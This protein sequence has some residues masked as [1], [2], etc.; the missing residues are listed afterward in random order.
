MANFKKA[1]FE[2]DFEAWVHG[3]VIPVLYHKYKKNNG[4]PIQTDKTLEGLKLN[5]KITKFLEAV[6]RVYM[7]YSAYELE[8]MTHKEQPWKE[9]RGDLPLDERCNTIISKVSMLKYYKSKI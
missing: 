4:S 2:E 1:L 7:R 6:A 5:P 9:A 8:L 3:P